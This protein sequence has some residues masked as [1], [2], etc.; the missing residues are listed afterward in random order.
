M[1]G[2]IGVTLDS[3]LYGFPHYA[4]PDT[5]VWTT[6][7]DG[8]WTGGFWVGQLW[9][10]A[11]LLNDRRHADGAAAWCRRLAPRVDSRSVFRSFLFY[12]GAA[13][14][15]LLHDDAA[16]RRLA[17]AAGRSVAADFD[18]QLGV[19]PLGAQAEEARS[20]GPSESN[21]DGLSACPLILWA[22]RETGAAD[23]AEI[24][25][26]HALRSAALFVREDHSVIQSASL[27]PADGSPLRHYT[28]KGHS[29]SSTWARAQ[30]WAMLFF[31][32][33]YRY[34]GDPALC[35]VAERV[36]DWWVAHAP[37][38]EAAYW[39]FDAPRTAETRRDTSGTAIAAVALFKLAA[40]TPDRGKAALYHRAARD[41]TL[42]LA[43]R[44]VT[45]VAQDDRRP[46][47]VL[48]DGCFDPREGTAVANELIWGS[49]FMLEALAIATGRL[50]PLT[51]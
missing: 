33:A 28:H 22:A 9:L 43:L 25:A 35:D 37:A 41:T 23:L 11:Y 26:L 20:V 24:G 13:S 21:V 6:T 5:G 49:Y 30:A 10:T 14:G 47:G 4:D 40:A 48:A 38:G 29:D 42:A 7:A 8:F 34:S 16:A 3:G 31:T 50:G 17:I 39:D 12:Y 44:H 27:D 19:I 51:V 1:T 36:S 2:R 46:P 15:A 32:Q 45:P 18:D